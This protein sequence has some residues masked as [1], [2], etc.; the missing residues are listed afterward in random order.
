MLCLIQRRRL[1]IFFAVRA[2]CWVMFNLAFSAKLYSSW[3]SPRLFLS[4]FRTAFPL[5]EQQEAPVDPFLKSI[6][7]PLYGSTTH[8]GINYFSQSCTFHKLVEGGLC[9]I[10]QVINEDVK[11]VQ[12]QYKP[13]QYTSSDWPSGGIC[14]AGQNPLS[15]ATQPVFH[16]PHCLFN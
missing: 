5:A 10:I 7:V 16:V 3:S 12:A 15:M 1:L 6:Q 14:A 11:T 13:L 2:H 4:S 8:W 9:P